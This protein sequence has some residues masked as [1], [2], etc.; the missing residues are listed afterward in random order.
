MFRQ[1]KLLRGIISVVVIAQFGFLMPL[2]PVLAE[3]A[4]EID[5]S[6]QQV[7]LVNLDIF[8][9]IEENSA[10]APVEV[11]DN[12]KNVPDKSAGSETLDNQEDILTDDKETVSSGMGLQDEVKKQDKAE[13]KVNYTSLMRQIKDLRAGKIEDKR[14]DVLNDFDSLISQ[15]KER[16]DNLPVDFY[17]EK[18]YLRRLK[19]QLKGI[20]N[21]EMTFLQKV[22]DKIVRLFGFGIDELGFDEETQNDASFRM[23]ESPAKFGFN[24]D[25]PG[26]E[27]ISSI[28]VPDN[29]KISELIKAY[30]TIEEVEAE[31]IMPTIEDLQSDGGEI[32]INSTIRNL[33]NDLNNNPVEIYNFIRQNITYEPYYGAK[34]GNIGCL[35]E[36]V[37]ND[38]DMA[39]LAISLMRAAGIPAH[40][41]KSIMVAPIGQLQDLL[42]I[43][44]TVEGRRT[45][46]GIFAWNKVPVYSITNNPTLGEKLD[47][48]DFT[49]ETHFALEWVFPEIYYDY[50]QR[51]GNIDNL[52]DL[53]TA[54]TTDDLQ[55][56]LQTGYKKQWLPI[57]VVFKNY[58]YIQ[59]P[60]VADIASFNTENFWYDYLQYQGN[61]SPLEK[62]TQDLLN[63]TGKNINDVAYQS[64]NSA[65]VKN[66]EILPPTMSFVLGEGV[67][68]D[69]QEI[70]PETWSVLPD[71]RKTQVKVILKKADTQEVVLEHIFNGSEI[72]NKELNLYY[73][74]STEADQQIIDS[75]GGIHAT[76]AE[77]VDI[78]PYFLSDY[79]QIDG[80]ASIGIG[81]SM[82]LRFEYYQKG[83]I[84]HDDEKF[85]TAGNQEGIYVVL[86]QV[87]EDPYLTSNSE[88]LLRGNVG[89]AREYLR[90]IQ[91]SGE[92]FEKSLDY[93]YNLNFARAVV[94][95]NRILNKINGIPTTFDFKGL[96]I[97]AGTYI[98]DW[99]NRGNYK[100][101][102]KDF[103]LLWGLESSY[104]EGQ[105]FDKITGLEGISTVIGLQYAYAHPADYTVHTIKSAN[106]SVIDSLA[107]SD[108]TKANMHADVQAGN[109]IITPNKFVSSGTWNGIFYI[110]LDPQW[111]GTYAIGEQ[112]GQNGGWTIDD[113]LVASYYDGEDMSEYFLFQYT[114][115][116]LDQLYYYAY[117]DG[118]I[119]NNISCNI[120]ESSYNAIINGGEWDTKYGFPCKK[121]YVTFGDY[122]HTYI[123]AS[124][125]VKY[126]KD[127]E[128]N[129]WIK[130]SDIDSDINNYISNQKS[131]DYSNLNRLHDGTK[132]TQKFSTILGTYTQSICEEKD[133]VYL[134]KCGDYAT[135]YY[136]P[137]SNNGDVYRTRAD[138]LDKLADDSNLAIKRTG[139]PTSDEKWAIDSED[140]DGGRYQDFVNGQVYEYESWGF[141][142]AQYTYGKITQK[143]NQEGGS[144][145]YL[146]FPVK[147]PLAGINNS[148]YQLFEG[149]K[150]IEWY[151]NTGEVNV[152]NFKKYRCEVY[153]SVSDWKLDVYEAHGV[154][155]T[156]LNTAEDLGSLSF[157][158]LKSIYNID[159]TVS[160]IVDAV[161]NFDI[162]RA[163]DGLGGA[164]ST[165][166][167]NLKDEYDTSFGANGCKA[168]RSYITGRIAGEIAL[169]LVPAA[170]LK[171][172]AKIKIVSRIEL[173][174]PKLKL[175]SKIGKFGRKFKLTNADD[176][177]EWNYIK[178]LPQ[179]EKGAAGENFWKK[180]TGGAKKTGVEITDPNLGNRDVDIYVNGKNGKPDMAYEVKNYASNQVSFSDVG[181]LSSNG[182]LSGYDCQVL[183]DLNLL[184]QID[185]NIRPVWV[186]IDKGP[187]RKLREKLEEFGIEIIELTN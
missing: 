127:G 78:M 135:V 185:K 24:Q 50:D 89:L 19:G 180:Y 126:Y 143:H 37:C 91:E 30:I 105:I 177:A 23:P 13:K 28:K 147:D 129:Y 144:G 179:A 22:I 168:R 171:A 108:N 139:L 83:V 115:P 31:S 170:K 3:E 184:N 56:M 92:S 74:G 114:K 17:K 53:S 57:D 110:S 46:Y 164:V 174:F 120:S 48:G 62:Y 145:G 121:S 116:W 175:V 173:A 66:Y 157:G 43:E 140:V 39:S 2:A 96:S 6:E 12:L 97:D 68:G 123:L 60:I 63:A 166:V 81:D 172:A 137:S 45:V 80:N 161:K 86:S 64:I 99:S 1:F 20:D 88:I 75:Y 32:I 47:N 82:I 138:I 42:G 107:L 133:G 54:S 125:G 113:V 159:D 70:L 176:I 58:D 101:H 25:I 55:A 182:I 98:N 8:D 87:Q 149:D 155:D 61:L 117:Q 104:Y 151:K 100:N 7:D 187:N 65:V 178:G 44:K 150:E 95:Q 29:Q 119:V 111:T 41:K 148:V 33:A 158:L 16:L 130:K 26:F 52:N 15:E 72:N 27:G 142:W 34:K 146:G 76:P 154:L 167:D 79:E 156:A 134:G 112:T 103:R 77:L 94:T 36:K 152:I 118:R 109:T 21:A 141:T 11:E 35:E 128:F 14:I 186:F 169:F 18:S 122:K 49:S 85:S 162:N 153:G 165:A 131:L 90:Q 183:K 106:E 67:D 4:R 73:K 160:G 69:G 102:K 181:C 124:A 93:N 38:V 40:Y 163:I 71:S 10:Q 84:E 59:K 5:M 51:G 132:Y 136:V 9:R